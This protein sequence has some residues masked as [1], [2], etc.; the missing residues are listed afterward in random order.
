[1]SLTLF[2]EL[3]SLGHEVVPVD[4]QVNPATGPGIVLPLRVGWAKTALWHFELLRRLPDTGATLLAPGGYPLVLGRHPRL[5]VVVHDLSALDAGVYRPGKRLWFRALWPRSLQKARVVFCIS[6]HTRQRLL[7]RVPLDPQRVVVMP[8]GVD[9]TLAAALR[10]AGDAAPDA[11]RGVFLFV[12]TLEVRKN[13]LRL[14]DAYAQAR[15][16]GLTTPLWLVGKPGHGGD[17]IL[18]RLA[19]P[20][21]G[22]AVV[23]LGPVDE[24]RLAQLYGQAKAFLFP[25]LDEGFGLPILEAMAA[26]TPV[27]TSSVASMPEVAG[28]AALLVDPHDTAAIAAALLR[29]ERDRGLR[30][31]LRSKGRARLVHFDPHRLA[32]DAARALET[33]A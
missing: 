31:A 26:A 16:A 10:I 25:S 28:D 30:E 20:D 1:M 32:A 6:E 11:A 9:P 14:L 33:L 3:K 19:A 18:R 24:I 8:L 2:R 27:L 15:A 13:L 5:A 22:G 12:G 4:W 17:A 7:E 21:L 29:L 23:H